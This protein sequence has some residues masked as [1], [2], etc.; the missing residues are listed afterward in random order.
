MGRGPTVAGRKN[1]EDAKRGK[2]FTKLIR[3]ITV[4]ARQ[5]VPD[6]ERNGRLRAG[7]DKAL[8][9]NM[10][11]NTID[12][13]IKRGGGLDGGNAV[14]ETRYEGYGP[15][16]V[17]LIIDCFTDN[18]NRTVADVRH[19]LNKHGGNLGTDGSVVF[20]FQR[21]GELTFE[22]DGDEA[23]AE[24]ILEAALEAGADD[25]VHGRSESTVL[26]A[27]DEF[28]AVQQ[29]LIDAGLD[30]L[31]AGVGMR[32]DNRIEVTDDEARE[33]LLELLDRLDDIDDVS[34]VYHNALLPDDG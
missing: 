31:H 10:P 5:G 33:S 26:C 17:A 22:T 24:R 16:G 30:S 29:S 20:Q 15:A 32:P 34:E 19:A 23:E 21:M 6:P 28:E 7:V 2:V 8:A 27:P 4:A 14:E 12:R 9:C 13:A 1:A 11:K 18:A 3:E 25:V